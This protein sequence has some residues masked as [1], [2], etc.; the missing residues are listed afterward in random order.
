MSKFNSDIQSQTPRGNYNYKFYS[1]FSKNNTNQNKTSIFLEELAMED[2]LIEQLN[3]LNTILVYK[4]GSQFQTANQD[5][6][7]EPL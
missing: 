5:L 7:N 6:D 3:K 2:Q 1:K 4:D